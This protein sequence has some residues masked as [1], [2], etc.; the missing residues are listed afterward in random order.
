MILLTCGILRSQ[1]DRMRLHLDWKV[2]EWEDV[3]KGT[4]F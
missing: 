2:G 1:T 4:N 3:D